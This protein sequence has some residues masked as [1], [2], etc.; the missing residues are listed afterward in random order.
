M[1]KVFIARTKRD[2]LADFELIGRPPEG[3]APR[4]G[5]PATDKLEQVVFE[6]MHELEKRGIF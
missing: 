5:Q 6:V 3:C 4:S 2:F 1:G